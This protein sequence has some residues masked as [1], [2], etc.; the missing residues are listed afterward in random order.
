M[1]N[2]GPEREGPPS[3]A[4]S[5]PVACTDADVVFATNSAGNQYSIVYQRAPLL[6]ARRL[7]AC[8][9]QMSEGSMQP[10]AQKGL[11][12]TLQKQGMFLACQLKPA[13]NVVIDLPDNAGIDCLAIAVSKVILNH[14]VLQLELK[15]PSTAISSCI[16]DCWRTDI[17]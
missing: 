9:M 5:Q 4:A 12:P 15:P 17:P 11:K 13:S 1:L 14:N 16:F 7:P 2:N 3:T 6:P 8:L 10:E